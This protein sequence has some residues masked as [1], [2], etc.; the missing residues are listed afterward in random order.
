M[1]PRSGRETSARIDRSPKH[2]YPVQY[3]CA[4]WPMAY[5]GL[6]PMMPRKAVSSATRLCGASSTRYV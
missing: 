5:G 6:W 2:P 4:L 1:P 3:N